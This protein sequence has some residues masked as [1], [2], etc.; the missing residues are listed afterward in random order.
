MS[1]ASMT[2][3]DARKLEFEDASADAV[4]MFGP[5]YHLVERAERMQALRE[6][7]R[8]LRP[9][10]V[11]LAVGVSRFASLIDGAAQGF[12]ADPV[13]RDIVAR[14]LASGRHENPGKHPHYFT[15]AYFHKP[16]ELCDEIQEAGFGGAQVLGVEGPVWS[17][18]G[19]E[20]AWGDPVQREALLGF[21]QKVEREPSVIGASAHV[22]AVGRRQG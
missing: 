8:V 2:V 17:A 12:I 11:L 20:A 1:L 7:R 19:F 10:G 6:A 13:F 16:E 4:L 18:A 14:D 5:M 3:G 21:L 22:I 15:T 9:Q